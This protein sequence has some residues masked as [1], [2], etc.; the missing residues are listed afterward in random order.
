MGKTSPAT[1]AFKSA[2]EFRWFNLVR[3]EVR[4]ARM[5]GAADGAVASPCSTYGGVRWFRV[6]K[7]FRWYVSEWRKRM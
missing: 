7:E 5:V 6:V 3:K 2:C 4:E 1:L